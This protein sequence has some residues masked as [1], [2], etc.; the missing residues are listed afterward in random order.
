MVEDLPGLA[1]QTARD[2]LTGLRADRHVPLR[3]LD[4]HLAT[5]PDAF[6]S[7][8]AQVPLVVT[9]VLAALSSNGHPVTVPCCA[10]CAQQ[11]HLPELGPSGR[12]CSSCAAAARARPCCRCG[13][14]A[15]VASVT[16]AGPICASCYARDESRYETCDRCGQ[17]RRVAS[18][19]EDGRPVCQRC[20]RKPV[21]TCCR[22]GFV[23][24]ATA[25]SPDGPL[26]QAC[27]DVTSRPQR[28][29]EGCGRITTIAVTGR[30]GKPD[31]CRRCN[32]PPVTT[33]SRCG[34]TR[35]C[36]GTISGEPVCQ[37]CRVVR[38]TPCTGCGR[39]RSVVIRWPIG[40]VCRSCYARARANPAR[41]T[42]CGQTRVLIGQPRPAASGEH[43]TAAEFVSGTV[44][45]TVCGQ[46]CRSRHTYLCRRCDGGL[47][48]YSDGLCVRCVARDRLRELFTGPDGT[49]P[50]GLQP[51]MQA[52]GDSRRPRSVL[53]WLDDAPGGARL[54][55]QL[56]A[57]GAP[58]D[59]ATLD[60]LPPSPG[61]SAVRQTLVHVGALPA[62]AENLERL[63]PWL[64]TFAAGLPAEHRHLILTYGHWWVLR[65]ARRRARG[66]RFTSGSG[67]HV[68]RQITAASA[69]LV[70]IDSRDL[71]LRRL[72]QP[73]L[74]RWLDGEGQAHRA[75]AICFLRWAARRGRSR[76]MDTSAARP[77]RTAPTIVMTDQERWEILNRCLHDATIPLDV[78]AA[79]GLLLLYGTHLSRIVELTTSAVRRDD[80]GHV[81]AI[82]L[83]GSA[84]PTALPPRLA[85]LLAALPA[86]TARTRPLVGADDHGPGRLFP[87]RE[88]GR[89]VI[90]PAQAN[91]LAVHGIPVRASRNAA[92]IA[93]AADLPAAVLA[94]S[95]GISITTAVAWAHHARRDWHTFLSERAE[96]LG[97]PGR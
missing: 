63:R 34:H 68:R 46:C 75:D 67:R 64:D 27:Y 65:R 50:A 82:R 29:C 94:D 41:C 23:G 70:W 76:T 15:A 79:G 5:A 39:D 83:P 69:L 62:R 48:P 53:K 35:R 74:E 30:D 93:I 80:A 90:T 55:R 14:T 38:T 78:R 1:D 51:W 44:S 86:P 96:L 36:Q 7:G 88:P 56:I 59:H 13:T 9:R 81:H 24:I 21:H 25:R 42:Q 4:R 43:G 84:G 57:A 26:C 6:F 33:C 89:H 52:L 32:R 12:V 47:E 11:R 37:S 22:C 2:L 87:G 58:V 85:A 92:L 20:H 91:R 72:T 60:R 28:R 3:E 19:E 31:L 40:P 54:L 18:R 71:D 16:E 77:H 61:V 10:S 49:T 66:H 8:N 17:R 73:D 97:Q 95:L 45:A